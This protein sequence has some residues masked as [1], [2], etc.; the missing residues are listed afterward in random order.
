MRKQS[1][2]PHQPIT[3]TAFRQW[4]FQPRGPFVV[5][6]FCE[7]RADGRPGTDLLW[8]ERFETLAEAIE[9]F[10]D[11]CLPAERGTM[12]QVGDIRSGS[13][14]AGYTALEHT[15]AT[16]GDAMFFALRCGIEALEAT[17]KVN[18]VDLAIW[19]SMAKKVA[20]GVSW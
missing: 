8:A 14:L 19:E 3:L 11:R 7:S 20:L 4:E 17:G 13:S 10:V 12:A 9:V 18:L 16:T 6:M 1:M 15:Y 2:N 5:Q